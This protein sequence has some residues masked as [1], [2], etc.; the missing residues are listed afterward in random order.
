[1]EKVILLSECSESN[2]IPVTAIIAIK[3][4]EI[5]IAQNKVEQ[6]RFVWEHA[7]YVAVKCACE[8]LNTKYLDMASIYV[9]LEPCEFC[10]ALLS[11]VRIKNIF[12]GAYNSRGGGI[13]HNA[14]I[15]DKTTRQPFIIGGIQEARCSKLLSSFFKKIRK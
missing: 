12:F 5:S 2:E 1:M 9:N 6:T 15:F 4:Q 13:T 10:S 11:A 7:E 3:N 8:K 14:R